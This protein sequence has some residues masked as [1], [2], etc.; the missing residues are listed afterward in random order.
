MSHTHVLSEVNALL[1]TL[2][3]TPHAS[4]LAASA[5]T[6]ARRLDAAEDAQSGAVANAVPG[7]S[8][9]LTEVLDEI[10]ELCK[11]SDD[12]LL[13]WLN[14][15]GPVPIPVTD[16]VDDPSRPGQHIVQPVAVAS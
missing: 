1:R 15:D 10:V 8:R 4:A 12:P 13:S 3:L 11:S 16:W 9:A 6:I 2:E 7:L 14:D 5:R